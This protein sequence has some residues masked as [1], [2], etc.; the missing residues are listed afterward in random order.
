[1]LTY[2][3]RKEKKTVPFLKFAPRANLR[4]SWI[5]ERTVMVRAVRDKIFREMYLKLTS[6]TV[7]LILNS[8]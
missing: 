7:I 5:L 4:D 1:M 8:N 6:K 3:K 2:L